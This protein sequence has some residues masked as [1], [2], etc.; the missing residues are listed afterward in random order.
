MSTSTDSTTGST[1]SIS[2][3]SLNSSFAAQEEFEL[4]IAIL[5][6]NHDMFMAG[7]TAFLTGAQGIR[8]A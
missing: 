5:T 2:L 7:D 8:G 4:S 6:T 3:D 1:S